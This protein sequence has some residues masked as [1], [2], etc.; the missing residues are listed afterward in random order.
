[1]NENSDSPLSAEARAVLARLVAE[2]RYESERHALEV[3]V[4]LLLDFERQLAAQEEELVRRVSES[5]GAA[6]AGG[7]SAIDR[8]VEEAVRRLEKGTP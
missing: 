1:M 5:F 6:P 7:P 3:A 8:M 2:G 4:G